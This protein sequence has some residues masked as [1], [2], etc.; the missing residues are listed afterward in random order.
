MKG[1]IQGDLIKLV[2][3]ACELFASF[4]LS[5]L[6]VIQGDKQVEAVF[7]VVLSVA[8]PG[9]LYIMGALL[10]FFYIIYKQGNWLRSLWIMLGG[11]LYFIGDN[12]PP[13]M[14]VYGDQ[15]DCDEVCVQRTQAAGL[16][17]LAIAAITYFPTVVHRTF[18]H[19]LN[20]PPDNSFR[21]T[22]VSVTVFSLMA[23]L[24]ELD[25]VYTAIERASSD[26]TCP[27]ESTVVSAWVYWA[28]YAFAFLFL[29][30]L[31]V[32]IRI[33]CKKLFDGLC[34]NIHSILVFVCLA[35]YLLADNTLP[36]AC[37]GSAA[38]S[39]RIND[40]VRVALWIPA[41]AIGCYGLVFTILWKLCC[42]KWRP[43]YPV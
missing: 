35:T 7:A 23:T 5:L 38:G 8:V 20:E 30:V 15:L 1:L 17:M 37:T 12:L 2:A 34:A 14:D 18:T 40:E 11:L 31:A 16:G 22:P 26:G 33:K 39:E 6:L 19:D 13:V 41:V 4:V 24:T 3:L 27:S 36:L 9:V 28:V 32:N 25:L 42:K 29:V 10:C 43:P 21:K